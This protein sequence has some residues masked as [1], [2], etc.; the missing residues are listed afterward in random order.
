[1]SITISFTVT[2]RSCQNF[3]CKPFLSV[4]VLLLSLLA[5]PLAAASTE[6][7]SAKPASSID[8]RY[9]FAEMVLANILKIT[10]PE[11]GPAIHRH[12]NDIM[13][14]ERALI[15]LVDG[16]KIH[17]TVETIQDTWVKALLPI[18]I[19]INKGITGY[20]VMLIPDKNQG[21]FSRIQS[22]QDLQRIK[23]GSGRQW[24]TTKVMEGAGLNLVTTV[25]Y[26]GLF[27][28]LMGDRFHA[29]PRG[30]DEA[31][32]ELA[33]RQSTFPDM[34]I[35]NETAIY[36]PLPTMFFVSPK[37]PDLA[38]R[39]QVGLGMM[40][41]DDSFNQLFYRYHMGIIEKV[42]LSKR[43]IFEYPNNTLPPEVPLDEARY[44]F[45]PGDESQYK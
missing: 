42:N 15:E 37:H 36:I 35:E 22:K 39:I 25:K 18:W 17:V 28:M 5:M 11:F 30:I 9:E 38:K 34:I 29:F 24:S 33:D 19:P 41:K 27:W 16:N 14:R 21:M 12:A 40:Y 13:S 32:R 7:I 23:L 43:R 2:R 26:E 8:K 1:M 3:F 4:V 10:E 20:R 6:V 44:W 45:K 31:P